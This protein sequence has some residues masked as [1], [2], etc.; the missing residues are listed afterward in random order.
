MNAF[1]FSFNMLL[2][3]TGL[4][5]LLDLLVSTSIKQKRDASLALHKL[6]AKATSV[7][8]VD[9]APPSPTPQVGLL[10]VFLFIGISI[11]FLVWNLSIALLN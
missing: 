2:N 5:V 4:E 1:V 11:F 3:L 6:A 8:S 9:A 10:I 7:L